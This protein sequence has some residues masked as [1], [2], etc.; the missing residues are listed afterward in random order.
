MNSEWTLLLEIRNSY[1]EVYY[2]FQH[3]KKG[4]CRYFKTII[5]D[6]FVY[7]EEIT[8]ASKV[9]NMFLESNY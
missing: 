3:V 6:G 8:E 2:K 1:G 9:P 4:N 7:S 5:G